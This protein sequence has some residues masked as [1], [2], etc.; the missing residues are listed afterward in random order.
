MEI[1][2]TSSFSS[3]LKTI[4]KSIDGDFQSGS[5]TAIMGPSGAGKSSL[6]NILAGYTLVLNMVTC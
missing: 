6:M 2:L 1:G 4:L 5:L 3:G